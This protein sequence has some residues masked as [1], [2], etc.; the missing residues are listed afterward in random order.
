MEAKYLSPANGSSPY[1][2]LLRLSK[3]EADALVDLTRL[4][5]KPANSFT[6]TKPVH[7]IYPSLRLR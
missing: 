3:Y 7:S 5:A 4:M 6:K 1:E 2:S